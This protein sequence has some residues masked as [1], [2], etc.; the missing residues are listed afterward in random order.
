MGRFGAI[1]RRHAPSVADGECAARTYRLCDH[2]AV[3]SL[4]R[5]RDHGLW[6]IPPQ[7]TSEGD[8]LFRLSRLLAPLESKPDQ[9]AAR[10]LSRFGSLRRLAQAPV[11]ELRDA[12]MADEHWAD[13][14][15]A[16]RQLLE[17]VSLDGSASVWEGR[18]QH[19]LSA[20]LLTTMRKLPEERLVAIFADSQGAVIAEETIAEGSRATVLLSPRLVFRMALSLDARGILLIHNHPSGS[21]EPSLLDIESTRT[22]ARQAVDLG[23]VLMDH[24]VVGAHEVTS[25]KSRGL[26]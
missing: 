17:S 23:L 1:H 6:D 4:D 5:G 13:A 25:M 10:L 20:R 2:G 7:S 12:A 9:I 16:V 15:I 19:A 11:A 18:D 3:A 26:F 24:L 14:L 22:L 21:A 8:D